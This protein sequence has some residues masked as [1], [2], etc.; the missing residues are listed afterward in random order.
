METG[1]VRSRLRQESDKTA[2]RKQ[3]NL[4]LLGLLSPAFAAVGLAAGSPHFC[5]SGVLSFSAPSPAMLTFTTLSSLQLEKTFVQ[6]EN[7]GDAHTCSWTHWR[8][9]T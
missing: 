2:R 5:G 6:K 4:L 3:F 1:F 8:P 7:E 9:M